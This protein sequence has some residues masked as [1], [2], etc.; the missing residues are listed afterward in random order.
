MQ[1]KYLLY[2]S[3]NI[4]SMSFRIT[5]CSRKDK[6]ILPNRWHLYKHMQSHVKCSEQTREYWT[7]Q[8]VNRIGHYFH[9]RQNPSKFWN[10][11]V[12]CT[13]SGYWLKSTSFHARWMKRWCS[14]HQVVSP[15]CVKDKRVPQHVWRWHP[16]HDRCTC[17]FVSLRKEAFGPLSYVN[18]NDR[19]HALI[20]RN[21]PF[22]RFRLW[23]NMKML[24][25]QVFVKRL[26]I[27]Q[28][29]K[30]TV[31]WLELTRGHMV[32][33]G[34]C[35]R[36]MFRH[37]VLSTS[38]STGMFVITFLQHASNSYT[39]WQFRSWNYITYYPCVH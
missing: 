24:W 22:E 34:K 12:K 23:I 21:M 19:T 32:Q 17:L 7:S 39:F 36:F 25:C 18:I 8:I 37:W 15:Y 3:Y 13:Q 35:I 16:S 27:S 26:H 31:K 20:I 5:R 6:R 11:Q 33:I 38:V 2:V 14:P 29:H 4:I 10:R 28:T 1:K 30:K 9:Q